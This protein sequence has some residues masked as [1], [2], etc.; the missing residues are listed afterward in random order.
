MFKEDTDTIADVTV[1]CD[2]D[3][4]PLVDFEDEDDV[5]PTSSTADFRYK[6]MVEFPHN[7]GKFIDYIRE[8]AWI[9]STGQIYC[10]GSST[11]LHNQ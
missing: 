11:V 5:C 7:S 1:E 6:S 8:S 9:N 2:D 10:R 3:C 4:P